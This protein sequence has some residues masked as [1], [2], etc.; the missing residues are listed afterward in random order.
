[1]HFF[2]EWT[3]ND[4]ASQAFIFF[5][6]GFETAS[7]LIT[8]WFYEM[9]K[10]PDVQKTLQNEID[11]FLA[12]SNGKITYNEIQKLEYLDMTISGESMVQ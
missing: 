3:D 6:A 10:N 12:N 4:L 5:V 1:M 9:V 7:T 8:F 11:N 2:I